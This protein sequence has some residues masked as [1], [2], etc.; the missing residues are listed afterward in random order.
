M[1]LTNC[2]FECNVN[3]LMKKLYYFL[4]IIFFSSIFLEFSSRIL[5]KEEFQSYDKRIMLFSEGKTFKNLDK[6]FLY[7][8]N[9]NFKSMTI[10]QDLKTKKLKT[11][12][13][14]TVKTNNAGLVQLNNID[15]GKTSIFVLGASETKGQGSLPWFYD[16]E[17]SLENKNFQLVNLGMIGTGPK[18]QKILF[19]YVKEKYK[20]KVNKIIIIFSSGYF[21]RTIWN[22]NDQQ[23][24]CLEEQKK[25]IGTEGIY[26]F[27]FN[28][29]DPFIFSNKVMNSRMN[30][31]NA[32][33][34]SLT[35]HNYIQAIKEIAKK[36]YFIKK[37]FLVSRIYMSNNSTN[38]S[39]FISLLS[40]KKKYPNSL[41]LVHMQSRV[42]LFQ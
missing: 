16:L 40:L 13:Y 12:Y 5:F 27:D 1:L 31:I 28:N 24:K 32:F 6:I 21:S 41:Y 3:F 7:K 2:Y 35:D 8:Q 36:S 4:T 10:Y 15:I 17:N 37:L 20:L 38:D 19:D 29:N 22:F 42:S 9:Q 26:G 25:C 18:Q 39:N 30:N 23:L 34:E 14:Y 33:K 11:E